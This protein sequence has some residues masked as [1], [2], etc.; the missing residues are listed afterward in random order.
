M[1]IRTKLINR[2]YRLER[3]L[4]LGDTTETWLGF[5]T[6]LHRAVAV[7]VPRQEML[8]DGPFLAE[9]LQRSRIATALHHRGIV[10]AFDSGEDADLPYLVTE[11]VGGDALNDITRI[12]APFDVDDVAIL[13]EQV[14]GALDYA[15]QRGFIHGALTASD[16]VVDSQGATKLL[17]LGIPTGNIIWQAEPG[18]RAALTFDDDVQALATIAFEMLTGEEPESTEPG[19]A[20]AAY[21][22]DPDVP[23]NASDIVSIGLGAGPVRFSSAAAFARS[24]RDWRT[25]DPGDY[26]VATAPEPE[27]ELLQELPV[28]DR[29]LAVESPEID[30]DAWMASEGFSTDVTEDRADRSNRGLRMALVAALMLGILAGVVVWRAS[31]T[32]SSPSTTVPTQIEVLA[33]LSGF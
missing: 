18:L 3:R 8:R 32:T 12:E 1:T 29:L 20:G 2:R 4:T 5:D 28:N 11:Y 19:S 9:F 16:I 31:D 23:R 24:F 10:A 26:Y 14:A 21:L 22:I 7:T 30:L 17:G 33:E 27:P 13:V 15:H 6:V 25:F